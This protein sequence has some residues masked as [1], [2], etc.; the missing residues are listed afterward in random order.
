MKHKQKHIKDRHR[1]IDFDARY[2]Y[3]PQNICEG[4]RLVPV[5]N[6]ISNLME[7]NEYNVQYHNCDHEAYVSSTRSNCQN[8]FRLRCQ[9]FASSKEIS[10]SALRRRICDKMLIVAILSLTLLHGKF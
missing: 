9:K 10:F 7:N 5:N 6:N 2:Q 1:P 4:L 3:F 8:K